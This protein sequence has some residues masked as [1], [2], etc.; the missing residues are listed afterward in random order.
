MIT[1]R[2]VSRMFINKVKKYTK[3]LVNKI[4]KILLAIVSLIIMALALLLSE[5][6]E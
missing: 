6:S 4:K 2:D 1:R 3:K 5:K